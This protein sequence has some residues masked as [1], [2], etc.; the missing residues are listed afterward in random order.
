MSKADILNRI[1][2]KRQAFIMKFNSIPNTL[3][4][5]KNEIIEIK[6]RFQLQN[7]KEII[8]ILGLEVIEIQK[9]NY[10]K[11]AYIE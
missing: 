6:Q 5:G 9:N 4:L 11:I 2:D 8:E 1:H 7:P 3:L 10:L